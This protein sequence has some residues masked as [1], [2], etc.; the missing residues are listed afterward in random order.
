MTIPI[1]IIPAKELSEKPNQEK[2]WD[3]ISV[4]WEKYRIKTLPMVSR[5]LEDKQGKIVDIGCGSGRNMIKKKGIKYYAV[6]F[7]SKQLKNA[8]KY[9][10]NENVD[11]KFFKL[12]ADDLS[13]F[14]DEM[15]DYGL[16]IATLHCLET[17]E[18]R[19]NSL[20]EFYRVL[21]KGAEGLISVWNSEDKRFN[22]MKG[23]IYMSWMEERKR[24]MRYYYL[25]EKQEL[26]DLLKSVGFEILEQ[27]Q[28]QEDDRFSKKNWVIKVKK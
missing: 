18:E 7:S 26:I 27:Y 25:Y 6:D 10:C 17:K 28:P 11:A 21:K 12:K 8:E 5:F 15:F 3:I 4:P 1:K 19:E 23:D 24:H 22:S 9:A 13:I 2:V 20:K 14:E 16:F